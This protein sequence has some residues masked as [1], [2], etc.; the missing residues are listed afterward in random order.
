[1]FHWNDDLAKGRGKGVVHALTSIEQGQEITLCY[2]NRLEFV[3]WSGQRRSAEL[4]SIWNFTC[5]CATCV[6]PAGQTT[7]AD[8][9]RRQE[10]AALHKKLEFV[11]PLKPRRITGLSSKRHISGDTH[12][13]IEEQQEHLQ[14]HQEI[15]D[16]TQFAD[17]LASI[18]VR[19]ERQGDA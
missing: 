4:D 11:T 19:D 16:L 8:D 2:L 1:M 13:H 5:G 14:F 3:L 9:Q 7:P 15:A 17:G 12:T 6:I 18:G 10:L